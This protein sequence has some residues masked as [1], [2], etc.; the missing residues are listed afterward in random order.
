MAS[1]R[2]L[3]FVD[4]TLLRQAEQ[5]CRERLRDDP[6]NRAALRSHAEVCRK[7]GML[8]EAA[9]AYGR[10]FHL[11][12]QD[13]E[14]GYLH[15][16]LGGKHWPLAPKGCRAAPFVLLRN[17]LAPEFHDALLPFLVSVRERFVPMM[18]GNK[19]Y[20]P[21]HRQ[22]LDFPDKWGGKHR[23][24]GRLAGVLPQAISRLHL[25]PF[26]VGPIEVCVR[27]YQDGHFFKVHQD[28]SSDALYATR[29]LNFVYYFHKSPRPY[30]GGELLLFDSDLETN[31]YTTARFTRVVPEDNALIIFPCDFFHSVTPVCCPS[32]EFEDSRFVI[33]GH[34]HKLAQGTLS[35][36]G[37]GANV[38]LAS[39]T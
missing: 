2:D 34:V 8:E 13:Q 5:R 4:S 6:D 14:A 27:A 39:R 19:Q 16:V 33:N 38:E 24:R 36:E 18:G 21:G 37:A 35:A 20:Q 22:A 32:R 29:V 25:P 7:L 17:F 3:L 11:D 30:T 9:A 15:A 23:F 1:N 10:L 26:G 28:T 31:A 12:P